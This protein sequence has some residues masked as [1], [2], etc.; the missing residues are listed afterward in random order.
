M[1][2]LVLQE[3]GQPY[4]NFINSIKSKETKR[5]YRYVL[6]NFVKHYNTSLEGLLGLGTKE[7]EQKISN[8]ITNMNAKGLSYGY[9]NLVMAAIFH[10]FDMNDVLLN[11]KKVSK[12]MAESKR[13]NK[14][15][16]YTHEEIKNLV[17]SG[18]YRFCALVLFL[19][20]TGCR[21]GCIP[22]LLY[23]HLD[24][25]PLMD[26]RYPRNL[27]VTPIARTILVLV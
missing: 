1:S 13:S 11:K 26:L 17:D 24:R 7:I 19:A 27:T 25:R 23:R 6:L 16:A 14:D 4:L 22:S 8:Y 15:R 12:F 2:S 20:A 9:I 5:E 21:I 10:F 3:E 18:D